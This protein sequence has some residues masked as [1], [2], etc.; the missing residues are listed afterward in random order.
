MAKE[1]NF[2]K[3]RPESEWLNDEDMGNF[4]QH[5]TT[6]YGVEKGNISLFENA[7][8]LGGLI[9]K[10]NNGT[11]IGRS[12]N[13]LIKRIRGNNFIF[14]P[15]CCEESSHWTLFVYDKENKTFHHY[16]SYKDVNNL[17]Y[18][19][20]FLKSGVLEV[21]KNSIFVEH[22]TPQQDNGID[23]GLY[24]IAITELLVRRYQINPAVM[25][26]EISGEEGE[27]VKKNV[28]LFRKMLVE[29]KDYFADLS[30]ETMQKKIAKLTEIRQIIA[31][32]QN[33]LS[34]NKSTL[35][36]L[37]K[38]ITEL[39]VLASS[40][41]DGVERVIWEENKVSNQKML[42]NLEEKLSRVSKGADNSQTSEPKSNDNVNSKSA[43]STDNK[44]GKYVPTPA[45]DQQPSQETK[46]DLNDAISQAQDGTDDDK[47]NA[48]RKAGKIH[49]E[50]GYQE[51]NEQ[52]KAIKKDLAQ[53]NP[54]KHREGII[55][56]I[57]ENLKKNNLSVEEL[58]SEV[59]E[60]YKKIK[61][62]EI[63][64]SGQIEEEEK[65]INQNI[66][67]TG[68]KKRFKKLSDKVKKASRY[69]KEK[70]QK[71]K[72]KI[73]RFINCSSAYDREYKSKAQS[74]L[75]E[76]ESNAQTSP[77]PQ[78]I[79]WNYIISLAGGLVVVGLMA[80]LVI[81]KKSKSKNR[82]KKQFLRRKEP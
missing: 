80:A 15:A 36:E 45:A 66:A 41:V 62:G 3:N 50:E 57:E 16:N 53:N 29:G 25:S 39:K 73:L 21:D 44:N 69:S 65:K 59:Q 52:I 27:E 63:K 75:V 24:V 13:G 30:T 64:E 47:V 26:W 49:G 1:L 31:S 60:K 61:N 82:R 38:A 7:F 35:E 77:S 46:N 34:K 19:R 23:C 37:Q 74:L 20:P 5:I 8:I 55:G 17:K 6:E 78:S 54:E 32:A 42:A 40:P 68:S 72:A 76:L 56:E 43:D 2:K 71:L 58:D 79:P 28:P 48:I 67:Q 22:Q 4:Y 12:A 33:V 14:I 70:I 18:F 9:K 10:F 51:Q 11:S 81:R